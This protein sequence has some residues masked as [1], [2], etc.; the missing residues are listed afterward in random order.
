M[1]FMNNQ[2]VL[3]RFV[4]WAFFV[5]LLYFG[6]G[7][8]LFWRILSFDIGLENNFLASNGRTTLIVFITVMFG[9][10]WWFENFI[11]NLTIS[12]GWNTTTFTNIN[13][14]LMTIPAYFN[15]LLTAKSVSHLQFIAVGSV[16]IFMCGY[17]FRFS[18]LRPETIARLK[19]RN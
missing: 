10:G 13:A 18:S 4:K 14:L 19:V 3:P 1:S 11:E 15:L 7:M 16:Y 9:L 2:V 5:A 17:F 12:K 6:V 8:L